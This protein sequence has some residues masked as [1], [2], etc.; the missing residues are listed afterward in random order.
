MAPKHPIEESSTTMKL[1][2]YAIIL[3][4]GLNSHAAP[5]EFES[6]LIVEAIDGLG[7]YQLR[8]DKYSEPAAL[9]LR[10]SL[11][12]ICNNTLTKNFLLDQ[13]AA[14]DYLS[15]KHIN[16]ELV[17]TYKVQD[18]KG[19]SCSKLVTLKKQFGEI[20]KSL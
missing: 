9:S 17:F 11:I 14:C 8:V 3:F 10:L 1:Y 4:F 13:L 2:L 6:K 16:S 15:V 19:N 12:V 5:K 20:C 18:L 7:K